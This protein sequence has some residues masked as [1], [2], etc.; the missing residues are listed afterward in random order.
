M[1]SPWRAHNF[2]RSWRNWRTQMFCC[3]TCSSSAAPIGH[4][5]DSNFEQFANAIHFALAMQHFRKLIPLLRLCRTIHRQFVSKLEFRVLVELFSISQAPARVFT[6]CAR[7]FS[8]FCCLSGIALHP[9]LCYLTIHE[10]HLGW[11]VFNNFRWLAKMSKITKVRGYPFYNTRMLLW[12]AWCS[13]ATLICL[14]NPNYPPCPFFFFIFIHGINLLN[15]KTQ[16]ITGIYFFIEHIVG[17]EPE[18]P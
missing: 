10:H 8:A 12:L 15:R 1:Y 3:R 7:C 17:W 5:K 13:H 9:V 6:I 16:F 14:K 18:G 11:C 4:V 2:I